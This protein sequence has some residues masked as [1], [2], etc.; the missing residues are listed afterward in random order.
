MTQ[1]TPS[2]VPLNYA[3]PGASFDL[4]RVALAQ[5]QM[6]WVIL[7]SIFFTVAVLA[8]TMMMPPPPPSG[9]GMLIALL[10]IVVVIRLGVIALMMVSVYKLG[11]ALGMATSSKV[12]YML[13]M[14]IPYLGIILL[15]IINQRATKLLTS[16]NIRVGLMGA[17][18]SD[19]PAAM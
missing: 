5:R 2:P 9:S 11:T 15:L 1:Q 7:I 14:L 18:L 13:G 16:N 6:M 19:I 3:S 8:Q 12:L 4:R 10:I 17:R